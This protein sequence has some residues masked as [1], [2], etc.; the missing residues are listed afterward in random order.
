MKILQSVVVKQ[1][2]TEKSKRELLNKFETNLLQLQKEK[3]QLQ[4]EQKKLEKNNK[5]SINELR[6][7]VELEIQKRNEK[8]K[9]VSFQI[10]QLNILP[11]GSELKEKE[12][13]AI[14]E[15][16]IGDRWNLT[17]QSEIII[18]DGIVQEIR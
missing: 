14:V 1:V 15:V 3:E 5:F 8:I 11:F 17:N 18:K 4:F 16:H 2:V 6:K 7:Q 10:E 9:L 12:V 13:Q